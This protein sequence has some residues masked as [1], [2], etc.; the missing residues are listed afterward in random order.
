MSQSRFAYVKT[1]ELP[2]SLLPSTYL[3][4]RLDGKGFSK[5]STAKG[6][7]KPNDERALKLMNSAAET[8]MRQLGKE[9]IMCAFGESDEYSFVISPHCS[10]YNRRESKI[11]S[12]CVSIFT[13]AYCSHW[14]RFFPT[15]P[16]L[17]DSNEIPA[18]DGRR[19][20]QYPLKAIVIDYLKWRQVDTHINNLYN[21]VFWALVQR[22]EMT[23]KQAHAELSGTVSSQKHEILF[24]RF[25]MN[26]NEE[27]EMFK[28]GSLLVWEEVEEAV[29]PP[30]AP[31]AENENQHTSEEKEKHRKERKRKEKKSFRI[32]VVH[33]DMLKDEFWAEG[34]G[35]TLLD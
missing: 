23:A 22:G 13:S 17:D 30:I 1:F 9:N 28:K 15:I 7:T 21:T 32:A 3:V 29:A 24:S 26:Y 11:L 12:T 18:F 25:G 6:F 16:L 2:D 5:F 19:I 14:P 27:P 4:L 31:K 34:R 35:R 10:L 20:V 8:L 33:E